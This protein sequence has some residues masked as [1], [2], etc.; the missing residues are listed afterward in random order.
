MA[1]NASVKQRIL[2]PLTKLNK[3]KDRNRVYRYP[4]L[5][6]VFPRRSRQPIQ[7]EAEETNTG[8]LAGDVV[9]QIHIHQRCGRASWPI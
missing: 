8:N 7:I 6:V 4:C 9:A 2:K 1:L 3:R 5:M